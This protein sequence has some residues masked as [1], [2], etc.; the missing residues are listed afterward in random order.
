M[1]LVHGLYRM[2][3]RIYVPLHYVDESGE[4][5]NLRREILENLHGTPVEGIQAGTAPLSLCHAHGDGLE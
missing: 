4:E 3:S 1:K 2:D 5:H